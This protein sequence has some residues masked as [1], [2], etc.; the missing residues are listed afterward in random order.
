MLLPAMAIVFVPLSFVIAHATGETPT[1]AKLSER[2]FSVVQIGLGIAV[3][4]ALFV[5]PVRDVVMRLGSRRT[6]RIEDGTVQV[7]DKTPF[8][9]TKWSMPLA[10]YQGIAHHTRAS[11]SGLRHELILVHPD[12]AKNVLLAVGDRIHQ[13]T[14][15]RAKD[16]L[17]LPEV[18]A[19]A[20]YA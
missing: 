4:C 3:W 2:P 17:R 9:E 13:S 11:L 20:L 15:D 16:L 14:L 6:V 18:P 7:A 12:P 5:L 19:R 1:F 8:G 10:S